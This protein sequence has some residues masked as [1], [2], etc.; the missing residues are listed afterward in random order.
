MRYVLFISLFLHSFQ[1]LSGINV[2]MYYSQEILENA[3]VE[4]AWLGVVLIG[5]ANFLAVLFISPFVDKLGRR[6]L[7]ILSGIGMMLS[8]LALSFSF[9]R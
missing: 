5:T 3:G 1:Q 7:L 4:N 6:F 2:V 9:Y 8:F